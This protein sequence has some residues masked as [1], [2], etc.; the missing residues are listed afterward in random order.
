MRNCK[1]VARLVA[2]DEFAEAGWMTRLSVRIHLVMCANCRQYVSQV[3]AIGSAARTI[4]GVRR[5]ADELRTVQ[6]LE[7]AIFKEIRG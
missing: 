2:S 7:N 3:Q 5:D 4:F 1:E 6:R